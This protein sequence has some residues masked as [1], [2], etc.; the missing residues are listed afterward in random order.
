MY[1]WN[2]GG[3]QQG[4]AAKPAVKKKT[5]TYESFSVKFRIS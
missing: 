3:I 5:Q 1:V 4:G 2:V